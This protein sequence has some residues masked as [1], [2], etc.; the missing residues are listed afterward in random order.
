M[1]DCLQ[2]LKVLQKET[3]DLSFLSKG[4]GFLIVPLQEDSEDF[5]L[6]WHKG[7]E[8]EVGLR[9]TFH[10]VKLKKSDNSLK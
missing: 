3:K 6:K 9:K 8:V 7:E 5:F 1:H 2:V 4:L 10:L